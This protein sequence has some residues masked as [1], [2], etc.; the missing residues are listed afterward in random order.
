MRQ[1][2]SSRAKLRKHTG[3]GTSEASNKQKHAGQNNTHATFKFV[4]LVLVPSKCKQAR[5]L[6][7]ILH[8]DRQHFQ[9]KY[10]CQNSNSFNQYDIKISSLTSARSFVQEG[11]QPAG[12]L[13]PSFETCLLR[14]SAPWK[15]SVLAPTA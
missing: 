7:F 15:R 8:S 14:T 9:K 5:Y 11:F 10:S 12:A 3:A 4:F 6:H 13:H 2:F 1:K